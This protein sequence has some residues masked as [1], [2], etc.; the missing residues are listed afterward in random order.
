MTK[1][2]NPLAAGLDDLAAPRGGVGMRVITLF[3]DQPEVLDAIRRA[4]RDRRLSYSAIANYLSANS[5]HRI[6]ANPV[7]KWLNSEGIE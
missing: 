7:Q 3:G 2:K 1:P 5:G 6:T 4:R